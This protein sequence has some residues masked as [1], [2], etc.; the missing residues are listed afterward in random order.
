MSIGDFFVARQRK[1]NFIQKRYMTTNATQHIPA[2]PMIQTL[3]SHALLYFILKLRK[4]Y[5][6]K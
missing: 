2:G 1:E 5:G 3:A 4:D 6:L